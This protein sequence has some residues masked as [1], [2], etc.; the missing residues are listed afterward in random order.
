MK[1]RNVKQVMLK[2]GTSGKGRIKE[3][4][5]GWCIFYTCMNM[6]HWNQ[7]KF[8]RRGRENNGGDEPN[9]GIIYVYVDISQ[10]NTLYNYH[11]LIKMFTKL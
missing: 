7:S 5:Y 2:G 11:T 4:E 1:D 9:L 3:N 10:G 8:L 6:E